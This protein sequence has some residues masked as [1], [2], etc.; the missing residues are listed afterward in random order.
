MGRETRAVVRDLVERAQ[1]G[2]R[3]AFA[4]LAELSIGELY[5]LAQLMLADSDLAQDAVQEALIAAWRDLRALRDLDR[6]R[7]W[8]HRILVNSVYR[9]ARN[10]RRA[11]RLQIVAT[12]DWGTPD[13][14]RDLENRDEIDRGFRHL[15][16]EHRAVLVAHHYL[17]LSDDE[18]AEMLGVPP[19][20]VK[21]RLHRATAAMRAELDA[22]SRRNAGTVT[23]TIR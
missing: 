13:A 18:V 19:G 23:W 15:S 7:P 21:S 17:G 9:A 6:F 10:E 12:A 16:A 20:T 14:A 3:Q 2:D 22:D 8:L 1:R 5:N 4:A 11:S